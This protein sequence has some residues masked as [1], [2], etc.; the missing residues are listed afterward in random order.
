MIGARRDIQWLSLLSVAIG[1]VGLSL[2]LF[3]H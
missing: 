2:A 1:I 3:R